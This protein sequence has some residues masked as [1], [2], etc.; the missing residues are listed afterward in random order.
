MVNMVVQ[1]PGEN[2]GDLGFSGN[3]RRSIQFFR[4]VVDDR[5]EDQSA[6]IKPKV[7]ILAQK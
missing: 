7:I 1:V 2:S 3:N 5:A 6:A 4:L